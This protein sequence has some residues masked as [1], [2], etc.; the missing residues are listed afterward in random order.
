MA[1]EIVKIGETSKQERNGRFVYYFN[2]TIV[3]CNP[4]DNTYKH[5]TPNRGFYGLS[6][7]HISEPTRPY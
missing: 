5:V 3:E 2:T 7:I 4:A 6:L 1:N